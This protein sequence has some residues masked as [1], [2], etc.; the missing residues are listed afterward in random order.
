VSANT[1]PYVV[2][3][4]ATMIFLMPSFTAASMML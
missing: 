1:T 3:L 4:E 2:S